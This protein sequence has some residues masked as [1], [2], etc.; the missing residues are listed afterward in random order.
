MSKCPAERVSSTKEKGEGGGRGRWGRLPWDSGSRRGANP[1]SVVTETHL[2]FSLRLK[3]TVLIL[4]HPTSQGHNIFRS[5]SKFPNF[6]KVS[7]SQSDFNASSQW[8][9]GSNL[10]YINNRKSTGSPAPLLGVKH[11]ASCIYIT[12]Q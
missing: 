7:T 3:E 9:Q 5:D 2:K 8:V 6:L 11:G 12:F 4:P 1:G 10:T